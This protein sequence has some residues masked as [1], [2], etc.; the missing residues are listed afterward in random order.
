MFVWFCF[1]VCAS[2]TGWLVT[3]GQ[4][5]TG[6]PHSVPVNNSQVLT[7]ARFAVVEFNKANTQERFAYKIMNITSAKM[8]I[9][10]GIN[11]ILEVRLGRTVCKRNDTADSEPCA[12]HPEPK[13]RLCHFIVT[14]VPWENSR[15]LT[16]N[17]CHPNKN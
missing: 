5:M 7:A 8:Q 6:E 4:F 9:V 17:E 16:R 1:L 11:Y 3:V 12:L 10:A 2:F 14:D 15:V 13:E